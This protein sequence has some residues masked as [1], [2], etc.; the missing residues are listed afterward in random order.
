[1]LIK[2]GRA[3]EG[4][5][6]LRQ[7]LAI[8]QQQNTKNYFNIANLKID[9]SQFLLS[10]NRLAEAEQMAVEARD[11]VRQNLGETHPFLRTAENNLNKIFEKEGKPG[12]AQRPE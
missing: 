10:Q 11:E 3:R 2:A 4:E 5:D 9:L 6:Y 8:Y 12:L 1:M 7:A